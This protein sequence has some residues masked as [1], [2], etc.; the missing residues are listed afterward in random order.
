MTPTVTSPV[1]RCVLQRVSGTMV[2]FSSTHSSTK[3]WENPNRGQGSWTA[4]P[5]AAK[6][7][8]IHKE[9]L[10][11]TITKCKVASWVEFGIKKRLGKIR[12]NLNKRKKK[13]FFTVLEAGAPEVKGAAQGGGLVA[14]SCEGREHPREAGCER[15]PRWLSPTLILSWPPAMTSP[16]LIPCQDPSESHEHVTLGLSFPPWDFWGAHSSHSSGI[17]GELLQP[18]PRVFLFVMILRLP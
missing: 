5:Q 14:E 6:V 4:L 13:L 7:K 11:N 16:D 15:Q 12:G 8:V 2:T 18:E 1:H 17:L 9:S 3:P 10:R